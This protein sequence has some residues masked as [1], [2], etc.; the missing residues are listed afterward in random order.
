MITITYAWFFTIFFISGSALLLA[1][2][3]YVS[4]VADRA[5]RLGY[6]TGLKNAQGEIV[7]ERSVTD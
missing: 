1:L 7:Y 6:R 4:K 2:S 3:I 5:W